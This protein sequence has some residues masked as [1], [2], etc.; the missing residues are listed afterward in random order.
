MDTW[1]QARQIITSGSHNG[2]LSK[3]ET[4]SKIKRQSER[5]I[6]LRMTLEDLL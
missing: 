4:K 6:T 3:G 5:H 2:G 1:T